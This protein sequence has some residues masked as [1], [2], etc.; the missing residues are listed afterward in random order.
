MLD[1]ILKRKVIDPTNNIA[2]HPAEYQIHNENNKLVEEYKKKI[3]ANTVRIRNN[4]KV[5]D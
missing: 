5:V 1:Y 3:L 2:M 4:N